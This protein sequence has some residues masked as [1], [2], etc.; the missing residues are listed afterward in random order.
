MINIT[1]DFKG[2]KGLE[3][4]YKYISSDK[5]YFKAQNLCNDVADKVVEDMRTTIAT[6]K[7]RPS[8]GS[9]LE[10]NIDKEI[11]NSVG[12][13][14]IGIGNINKLRTNAPYFEVLDRGGYVPYSTAKGAPL[15]SFYGDAP[16]EGGEGQ[17]WERSG[18]KGFFMKPSKAIQGIDY[19][20]KSI[21]N[22]DK[23]LQSSIEILLKDY[24]GKA[25]Q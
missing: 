10:N 5:L 7:K 13:V 20:G 9:N 24:L 23:N 25:G 6:S 1:V 16:I 2:L 14:D 15:G 21:R 12:G 8:L 18:N 3:N 19:I 17:N 22:L 4:L 11:L